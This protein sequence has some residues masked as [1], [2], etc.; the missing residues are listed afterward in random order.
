MYAK[1]RL[2]RSYPREAEAHSFFEGQDGSGPCPEK[3]Q[4]AAYIGT[5][6]YPPVPARCDGVFRL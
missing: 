1:L 4:G 5:L 6:T 3:Q 2:F